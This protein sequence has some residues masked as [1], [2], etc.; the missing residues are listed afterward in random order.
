MGFEGGT[1]RTRSAEAEARWD[2]KKETFPGVRA[3]IAIERGVSL[4]AG[5]QS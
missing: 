3:Y 4:L 2:T 5:G 1:P